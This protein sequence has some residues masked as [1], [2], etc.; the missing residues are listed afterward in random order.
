MDPYSSFVVDEILPDAIEIEYHS[1]DDSCSFESLLNIIDEQERVRSSVALLLKTMT[2]GANISKR[3]FV[4]PS[5]WLMPFDESNNELGT[6]R[7]TA[8]KDTE[9]AVY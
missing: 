1:A 4:S 6:E 8:L 3:L 2:K 5:V 7:F 9:K